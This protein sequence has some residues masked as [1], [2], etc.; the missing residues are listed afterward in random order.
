MS[1]RGRISKSSSD[2]KK[3]RSLR[4]VI[5]AYEALKVSWSALLTTIRSC[6]EAGWRVSLEPSSM[7]MLSVSVGPAPYQRPQLGSGIY[8]DIDDSNTCTTASS[9]GPFLHTLGESASQELSQQSLRSLG[10]ATKAPSTSSKPATCRSVD[11]T[12]SK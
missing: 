8:F 12:P 11:K 10:A 4:S 1:K 9:S 6:Q 3:E 7:P 2:R 5:E